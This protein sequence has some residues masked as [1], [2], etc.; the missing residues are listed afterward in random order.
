MRG[1]KNNESWKNSSVR[2]TLKLRNLIDNWKRRDEDYST[3]IRNA[4][5]NAIKYGL[6]SVELSKEGQSVLKPVRGEQSVLLHYC[7]HPNEFDQ[8]KE[9]R[10]EIKASIF[11]KL[12]L[13]EELRLRRGNKELKRI[14]RREQQNQHKKSE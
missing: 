6:P 3:F 8:V 11:I 5:R 1:V 9:I 2:I 7:L 10:G 13:I 14:F 4:I 12:A